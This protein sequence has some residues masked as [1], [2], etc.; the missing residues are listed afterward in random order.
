M[1]FPFA[2]LKDIINS[3]SGIAIFVF[4]EKVPKVVSYL[5]LFELEI[6]E[7]SKTRV[8]IIRLKGHLR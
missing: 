7:M 1:F 2:P 5:L 3:L 6:V 4:L 8:D